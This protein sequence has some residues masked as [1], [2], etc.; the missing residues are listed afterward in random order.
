M[1]PPSAE[2][3]P[4]SMIEA[5]A[6]KLL[7]VVIA[8]GNIPDFNEHGVTGWL[9]PPKD[10]SELTRAMAK[11]IDDLILLST[12]AKAVQAKARSEFSVEPAV[13]KIMPAIQEAVTYG[14][15]IN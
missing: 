6:T 15:E 4:N 7:V 14:H 8:V 13:E 1:L 12:M 10:M 5:T 2:G 3:L 9:V 11:M